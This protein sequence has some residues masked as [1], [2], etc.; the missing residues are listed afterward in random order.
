MKIGSF[1]EFGDGSIPASE[2]LTVL[3]ELVKANASTRISIRNNTL[4]LI[5]EFDTSQKSLF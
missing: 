5:S 4:Y 3:E 1:I 2:L